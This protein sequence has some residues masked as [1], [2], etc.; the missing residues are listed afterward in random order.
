MSESSIHTQAIDKAAR[1]DLVSVLAPFLHFG[2][3]VT[4]GHKQ[5]VSVDREQEG[6]EDDVMSVVALP[7]I[8]VDGDDVLHEV[9]QQCVVP[10]VFAQLRH[11]FGSGPIS[12]GTS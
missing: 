3:A 12:C 8:E 10:P 1:R 6:R 11:V 2:D 5:Q 4:G 7:K 9:T